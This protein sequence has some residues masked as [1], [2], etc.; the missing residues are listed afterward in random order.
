MSTNDHTDDDSVHNSN[1]VGKFLE[2]ESN[3]DEQLK[4]AISIAG[5]YAKQ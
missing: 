5:M 4:E 3:T 1:N 2:L